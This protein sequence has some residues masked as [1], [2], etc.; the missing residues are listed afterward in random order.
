MRDLIDLC[1][2][3]FPVE[4]GTDKKGDPYRED[5]RW[6]L[7]NLFRATG[8]PGSPGGP[9]SAEPMARAIC[10]AMTARSMPLLHLCPLDM[11]DDLPRLRFGPCEIRTFSRQELED[12]IQLPRLRRQFTSLTLDTGGLSDFTWLV[13]RE[14]PALQSR[15]GLR[16][17]FWWNLRLDEDLGA[18]KP[19]SRTWPEA[20]ERAVFGLLLLPWEEFAAYPDMEWRGF[21]I[22]WVYTVDYDPFVAPKMPKGPE[23]LSREPAIYQD[24]QTG[25]EVELEKPVRLPLRDD[26]DGAWATV[27]DQ[28][29]EELGR[30]VTS[31][32]VNPLVVHFLV[33]AFITDDIDEFLGHIT[34]IEAAL[35]MERDHN[36]DGARPKINGDNPGPTERIARRVSALTGDATSAERYREL[37]GMRSAFVHG[38]RLDVI[39]SEKRNQARAMARL[40]VNNLVSAAITGAHNNRKEYLSTLCP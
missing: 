34:T 40:V 7:V 38:R 18:I 31:P 6:A 8:I 22:P 17:N 25:E 27:C 30:A 9:V 32:I 21:K 20:V 12:V 15:I 28:W 14:T 16:S 29:W 13:V 1:I 24:I 5:V 3:L 39:S 4:I 33:R 36:R 2:E 10:E 11:A 37:F 35:G 19:Y 23:T 26:M